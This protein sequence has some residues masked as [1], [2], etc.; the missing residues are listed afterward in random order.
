MVTMANEPDAYEA[1]RTGRRH[2][3]E[4]V[5]AKLERWLAGRF[6]VDS[7]TLTGARYPMGAG[8]SSE[9]ILATATWAGLD[10]PQQR[11]VAFRVQ[12]DRFQLFLDPDFELQYKAIDALHR[13]GR[14]RVPEPWYFEH[15]TSHIGLTFFAM[16]QVHG[17][18]P[19]SSPPYNE[20]GFLFDATPAQR[21]VAWESATEELCRIATTPLDELAFLDVGRAGMSGLERQ[22][23]YWSRMLDWVLGPHAPD[24]YL[25]VRHWLVA[26]LPADRP[27]GLA[28]GDARIGNMV[29]GS[30]FRLAGV[31]DWEQVNNGGI[32]Q[33]LGWWLYFDDFWSVARGVKRLDGLGTRQETIDM[34]EDRTGHVAGD[35]TWY[36]VLSGYKVAI[37]SART[38]S[39][40]GGSGNVAAQANPVLDGARRMAGLA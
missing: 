38:M 3:I 14:V 4:E 40:M 16:S 10:G 24:A 7:V 17:S 18:V 31:L 12:P 19:V 25:E 6:G 37:L 39:L 27:D 15:D 32:H 20:A 9:T 5:T 13:T 1:A 28:W 30:D 11:D 2:T 21:R 8:T 23:D 36:E 35:L 34:W 29:F 22:I 26:N 33:D